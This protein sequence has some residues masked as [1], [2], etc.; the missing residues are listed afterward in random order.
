[1]P[2]WSEIQRCVVDIL[3]AKKDKQHKGNRLYFGI[4]DMTDPNQ[5]YCIVETLWKYTK[6]AKP[7]KGRSFFYIPALN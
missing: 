7:Q 5:A 6:A 3:S 2:D 4:A 1:M